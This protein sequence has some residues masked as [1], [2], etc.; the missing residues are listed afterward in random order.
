VTELEPITELGPLEPECM[1]AEL[2]LEDVRFSIL[3][4]VVMIEDKEC[5][6]EILSLSRDEAIRFAAWITQVLP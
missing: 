2:E 1:E 3:D 5:D 4:D 6:L